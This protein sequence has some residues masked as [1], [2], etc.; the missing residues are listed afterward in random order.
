MKDMHTESERALSSIRIALFLLFSY[1]LLKY[2]SGILM[3][4]VIAFCIGSIV[5]PV[6]VRLARRVHL[7]QR[8]CAVICLCV[9]LTLIG[10][11]L[12]LALSRLYSELSSLLS[13]L[14]DSEDSLT[15]GI[16]QI[17]E[18]I[19]I[20]ISRLPFLTNSGTG[21]DTGIA[22]AVLKMSGSLL[23][24]LGRA[25][26]ATPRALV[27]IAVTLIASF[28]LSCDLDGIKTGAISLLRGTA[29]A[30]AE[31]ILAT[32]SKAIRSCA[33]A[34]LF[35]FL[36]TFAAVLTGL[37]LLRR[38]YA[39]LIALTVAAVD[40]LPILGTGAVLIPWA[41]AMVLAEQ[42]TVGFGLLALYG[43]VTL[44]RQIAE[45]RIVGQSLGVHPLATLACMLTAMRLFGAVG[46]L[47]GPV[48]AL[49]IKEFACGT[50]E[51]S[52]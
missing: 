9:L 44:I 43:T 26:R 21:S 11:V 33:R 37:L 10:A 49:V 17:T 13:R 50:G 30:R 34:Y 45:P 4:F 23:T 12:S 47:I 41:L 8:L 39:F 36:L 51:R 15:V 20:L 32:V 48:A 40:I 29:R 42:Y 5:Y 1:L 35:L 3:P 28:Y 2:A 27:S 18:R 22:Q 38:Q 52:E 46:M 24:S 16:A 19:R 31:R 6:S 25:V 7:P 14:S